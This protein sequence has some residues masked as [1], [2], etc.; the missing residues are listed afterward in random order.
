MPG[1]VEELFAA[2]DTIAREMIALFPKVA[3]AIL[4][5]IVSLVLMKLVDKFVKWLV[6]ASRLEEFI[7]E[8]MPGGLRIPVS[9]VF[10]I[11]ANL[12]VAV[13]AIAVIVRMF[14]P[15]YTVMYKESLTY[16]ARAASIIVLAIIF[17][18]GLDAII[19]TIRIERKMESFFVTLAFLLIL[20][21]FVDLTALSGETKAAVSMGIAVGIGLTIGAFALW[22]FFSD[23]LKSLVKSG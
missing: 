20:A 14:V 5:I 1:F 11:L 15:E 23:Y 4:V 13:A 8:V 3:L 17:I 2:F 6:R 22:L 18:V 16:V 7:R 21:V 10:S 9:I 19:K 12:G